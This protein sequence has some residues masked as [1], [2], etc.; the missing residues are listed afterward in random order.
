MHDFSSQ[1]YI[2]NCYTTGKKPYYTAQDGPVALYVMETL[3]LNWDDGISNA[4]D[5]L[6]TLVQ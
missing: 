2:H 5:K 6:V 4:D 1:F 3:I